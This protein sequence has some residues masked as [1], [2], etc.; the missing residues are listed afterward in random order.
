MVDGVE[1]KLLV[2]KVLNIERHKEQES[3]L[4]NKHLAEPLSK[5]FANSITT[6]VVA[7]KIHKKGEPE[8][9][10]N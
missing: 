7:I 5:L 1:K 2:I 10:S 6:A 3:D 4:T 8:N 9:V